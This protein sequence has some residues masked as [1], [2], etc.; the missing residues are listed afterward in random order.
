MIALIKKLDLNFEIVV[1]I[2]VGLISFLT[3]NLSIALISGLV[4]EQSYG[5]IKRQKNLQ[6]EN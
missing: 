6:A 5:Y 2:L 1:A 3:G 4:V